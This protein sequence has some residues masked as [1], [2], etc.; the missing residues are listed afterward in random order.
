M[1]SLISTALLLAFAMLTSSTAVV[2]QNSSASSEISPVGDWRGDS[3][4][5][6]HPSACQDEDSLYHVTAVAGKPGQFSMQADKIVDGK[7]QNMG[8]ADCT[9]NAKQR[10]LT[11]NLGRASLEFTVTENTM[12]G[13]MFRPDKT[14]WR[15]IKLK[16]VS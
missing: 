10:I 7:P 5:Q 2:A 14:R 12:N 6:V 16:K 9:Y 8:N 13:A 1:K 11:C 15:D 4:C 3:I